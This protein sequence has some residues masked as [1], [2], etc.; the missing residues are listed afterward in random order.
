M[1]KQEVLEEVLGGFEFQ[2]YHFGEGEAGTTVPFEFTY[3]G[4]IAIEGVKAGCGCT[5]VKVNDISE[6]L[7]TV[8]GTLRLSK[9][10]DIEKSYTPYVKD[11]NGVVWQVKGQ[12]AIPS[13]P[14]LG[15]VPAKEISGEKLPF[16]SKT[17]DVRFADGEPL[18]I[19]TDDKVIKPN[20]NKAQAT[21]TVEGFVKI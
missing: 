21:L 13:D 11:E 4:V 16:M 10:E 20:A 17:I 2:T 18:E 12:W 1:G 5:N 7:Q 19:V 8:T 3:R 6:G 9:K 14:R 15:R